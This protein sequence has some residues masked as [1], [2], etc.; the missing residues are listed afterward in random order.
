MRKKLNMFVICML[1][2]GLIQSLTVNVGAID[3]QSFNR[4]EYSEKTLSDY[5][6]DY[7]LYY[8]LNHFNHFI[9]G[10]AS[11]GHTIGAV[12]VGGE[13]AYSAGNGNGDYKQTTPSYLKGKIKQLIPD[14]YFQALYVGE[15]NADGNFASQNRNQTFISRNDRYINFDQAFQSIKSELNRYQGNV[16]ITTTDI[17]NASMLKPWQGTVGNLS[18]THYE[19]S[20]ENDNDLYVLKLENGYSYQFDNSVLNKIVRIDLMNVGSESQNKDTLLIA[21]D[22]GKLQLPYIYLNGKHD[23]MSGEWGKGL[24]A[25][26]MLKNATE[27]VSKNAAQKHIGH[28]IAPLAYVHNMN[29]DVNGSIVANQ[30][31][32]PNSESHMWTYTGQSLNCSTPA[33]IVINAKKTLDGKT[34][35]KTFQFT[36]ELVSKPSGSTVSYLETVTNNKGNIEF[37]ELKVSHAGT[38][39]FKIKEV[40]PDS[41]ENIDYDSQEYYATVKVVKNGTKYQVSSIQYSKQMNAKTNGCLPQVPVFQN[42]TNCKKVGTLTL[43]KVSDGATTPEDTTFTI[44]GPNGFSKTIQYK[45]FE[46]GKYTFTYLELGEYTVSESNADI[47]GYK[48]TVSGTGK[49][50]LSKSNKKVT[51]TITNQYEKILGSLIIEKVSNGAKTP[52]N[53]TFTIQGPNGYVKS[54]KYQDFK[55]GK[56]T[57]ADLELGEYTVSENNA[58][59]DGYKLVVNGQGKATLTQNTPNVTKTITNQYEKVLGS[60]TIVK[61]SNG[62]KTPAN[63]TFTI[64]G[65]N[66]YVK[67]VKYQDFKNGKYTLSDLELGEYTVNENNADV[68]GYKLSVSGQG[69][70]TLT[71][72]DAN[73]TQT[74][75]N[76]YE[77]VLGTLVIEKVSNGAKTPAN[78]TFTIQGPNGYIKSVKYQDFKAGK[79]TLSNLELGEYTVSESNADVDGYKLVVSGDGKVTLTSKTPTAT[80]AITN[81]YE[82]ILGSLIIEKVSN[83]AKTPT[84]ATFTIQGPNGYVKSV[85]YQDFKDGKYTLA[86]LELGEYTVNENNADVKGYMLKSENGKAKLTANENS[87]TVTLTNTYTATQVSVLKVDE[88]TGKALSGATLAIYDKDNQLIEKWVSTETEHVLTAKLDVNGQYVLKELEAP[89]G[90]QKASDIEFTVESTDKVSIVMKDAKEIKYVDL[91]INKVD[92]DSK[93][94][95]GASFKLVKVVDGQEVE[96][97]TLDNGPQFVFE[98]LDDGVYR[99]Y[100][101]VTPAGYKT[102]D[103]VEVTIDDGKIYYNG[104]EKE[105][106]TIVNKKSITVVKNDDQPKNNEPKSETETKTTFVNTSD[107]YQAMEY[108]MAGMLAVSAIYCLKKRKYE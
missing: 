16:K 43:V 99:L 108:I 49:V 13:S 23:T 63:A 92:Q 76:T 52:A 2:L 80:K 41:T 69:K 68:D 5:G 65:P 56:Y 25:V 14:G 45:D 77:K 20:K 60:L 21:N 30:L 61:V 37:P 88:E 74:I 15:T 67:S 17:T 55:E 19:L 38:Y 78:A 27:V 84:D 42:K 26:F 35:N 40:I 39:V 85:K 79:Y 95:Q 83:G 1:V 72:K 97:K 70:T 103:V 93:P 50:T 62:A 4:Y 10:N 28:I 75:T 24:S 31:D 104:E 73:K 6:G 107:E 90:Y 34:P 47:D 87:Q 96:I 32:I 44:T 106:I 82:K 53:A 81:Q 102:A 105:N 94:L 98:H 22:S 100:E 8:I 48:L 86:D 33:S 101:T 3:T 36:C 12:A 9:Y 57:L 58:D 11:A 54:V 64:Q 7:S 46:N 59:V 51:Q 71:Q 91:V 66:G 89:K 29:G 18:E